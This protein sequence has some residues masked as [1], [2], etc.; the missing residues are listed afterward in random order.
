MTYVSIRYA[1]SA[2]SLG[3]ALGLGAVANADAQTDSVRTLFRGGVVG[4]SGVSGGTIAL[5]NGKYTEYTED[6]SVKVAGGYVTW[7][8]DFNGNQ[9]RFNPHWMSLNFEFDTVMLAASGGGGGGGGGGAAVL[10]QPQEPPEYFGGTVIPGTDGG[11]TGGTGPLWAISR[12]GT[13]FSAESSYCSFSVQSNSRYLLKPVFKGDAPACPTNRF[14]GQPLSSGTGGGGS[15]AVSQLPGG[16][17]PDSLAGFRWEDRMGDWIEYDRTG[18][19]TSYGDRNNI[20]V[21]MQYAGGKMVAVLDHTGRKVLEIAYDG[22]R[23]SEVRDVPRS[24]D[25]A[26][27][28]VVKYTYASN[29]GLKT[30]TDVRGNVMTYEYDDKD[31]M[32][33]VTDQEGR[34]RTIAYGPTNRVTKLTQPDGAVTEYDYEY[35]ATK[36][37]FYAKTKR[38]IVDGQQRVELSVYSA[39]GQLVSQSV[40]GRV[41]RELGQDGRTDKITDGRGNLTQ[42]TRNEFNQLTS[43]VYADGTSE[44]NSFNT[45]TLQLEQHRTADGFTHQFERDERGNLRRQR[46]AVGAPD[47]RVSEYTLDE[48]ARTVTETVKGR[49]EANGKVTPDASFAYEYDDQDNVIRVTDPEGNAWTYTY[50]RWGDV[51]TA[52]DARKG[53]WRYSYDA[54]GNVLTSTSPLNFVR[55]FEYDKVGNQLKMI[56]GRG[57][58]FLSQFDER[59]RTTGEVDPY[60]NV[61]KTEY[62]ALGAISNVTDAAG[63][64]TR[65]AYDAWTRPRQSWDGK[66]FTYVMGYEDAE[67]VDNGARQP[68]KVKYPTFDRLF[69]YDER[70][71]LKQKT[72]L[73]GAEGR[74]EQYGYD[75]LG[76]RK[77]IT[78]ANGKTSTLQYNAFGQMT[79]MA[80]SLGNGLRWVYDAQGRVSEITDANGKKTAL[81]YDRRGLVTRVVNAL[82]KVTRYEYDANG[83]DAATISAN[84]SKVTYEHDA[85]GRLT[86]RSEYGTNG[87]LLKTTRYSYDEEDNLVG[88]SD[89][90]FSSVLAYDDAERLIKESINY[91]SF[92]SGYSYSY[93]PNNQVKT[94]TGP[95]GVT[96]TYSYDAV[97]Q[98]ERVSIPD[99]G[100]IS[101]TDW[102]WAARKTVLLPGGVEQRLTHDGLGVTTSLKVVNPAQSTVF[103]LQQKFGLNYEVTETKRDGAATRYDYDDADRLTQV[104]AESAAFN[105]GY[106]VDAAGNRAT[107]TRG[108]S[109]IGST[110]TYNDGQQLTQRGTVRYEWDDNGNL[111]KKVDAAVN[112]SAATVSYEYDALDRLTVVRDGSGAVVAR[113][114]YDP[115]DRRLSKKLGD[116]GVVTYYLPAMAGLLAEFDASGEVTVSYGWHPEQ[117]NGVYPLYARV[118]GSQG[119]RYV[120][121]HNDPLGTPQRITDK[122]GAVVWAA[123]YDGFGKATVKTGLSEP[124]TNNL[125]FPGQYFDAETQLHYNDRRYYDPETGRYITRDPL[126]FGGGGNLYAYAGHNPI[127]LTDP[128]GEI[129]PCIAANYLRCLASCMLFSAVTDFILD[130]GNI[131][132]GDNLKEC[133][134]DCLLS[135]IPIPNPCG[136]FGKWIS[137][138]LGALGAF[139]SFTPETLVHVRPAGAAAGAAAMGVTELRPIGELK[140]GD[141]VLALSEWKDAGARKGVDERLSYERITDVFTSQREQTLVHLEFSN[142][143]YLV[144]TDGHPLK[145]TEGWRDAALLN[146]GTSIVVK[147]GEGL[148]ESILTVTSVRIEKK[149]QRVFNLEVEH[150]HT[151]FVG[152]KGVL[153]HNAKTGPTPPPGYNKINERSHGQ[154]VYKNGNSYITPDIDGHNGGVWKKCKGSPKNLRNRTTRDG[155]YN[156]DL[157]VRIG[158]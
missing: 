16:G 86:S 119:R 152:K 18:R 105:E 123:D 145:T 63:K 78:N 151:F 33:S 35:D 134:I 79:R 65:F 129:L 58:V 138:G 110:W 143:E 62:N 109:P 82:G 135:M 158:D 99:E 29:G 22:N 73:D 4:S 25:D 66:G 126:G 53:V 70:N 57:K 7:A 55:R 127:N 51:L 15:G 104:R 40:N 23:I 154:P 153:V 77:S 50:T 27:A 84:G 130:C 117:D 131:N 11:L 80:D 125:R 21:T 124:V 147:A 34:V 156:A 116:T 96:V 38:P 49:V 45:K 24:S 44:T 97:G 5:P 142:G 9:W 103:E 122:S 68:T 114:S 107:H 81:E 36:K 26:P 113:Y 149:V 93:Y 75:A 95:D 31:R 140:P 52:T 155:T 61:Y 59:N 137:A 39:D 60:G 118:Q 72:D 64:T 30:V 92:V 150:A 28:R 19:M 83:W 157:T 146:V 48:R 148:P 136:K 42:T 3:L 106:T 120:Y 101:V 8:R 69:K 102:Q 71:R 108:G 56:D 46:L 14:N 111:S 54:A 115:F 90:T 76:R 10:I 94:F 132:W 85:D 6:I 128:T 133:A 100:D 43:V 67:G 47:E 74:V 2:I 89:G 98:L 91:G 88:W 20:K 37:L 13:W 144:A 32:K 12:N 17:I 141:E 1:I 139:N 121:Y 87:T 112:G 41:Q